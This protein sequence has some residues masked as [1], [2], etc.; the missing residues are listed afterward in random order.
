MP[1]AIRNDWPGLA[2]SL[3]ELDDARLAALL[4][5]R[6]DLASPPPRDWAALAARAGAWHSAREAL[7]GL[8]RGSVHVVE[9]LCLL[10]EPALVADVAGLLDVAP[11]DH[12]LC[13]AIDNLV[14]RALVFRQGDSRLHLLA[15]LR[16]LDHPAGLG[17]PLEAVLA[18]MTGPALEQMARRLGLKPAKVMAGTRA[19]ITA[20][21]SDPATVAAVVAAGPQ[22]CEELAARASAERP[23]VYVPGGMYGF[24][25]RSPA[26][27]MVNRGLLGIVD[28]YNA[29][30][31]RE[32]AV[33]LRGG[34]IFAAGVLRRPPLAPDPVDAGAVDR[35][36]AEQAG[37]LVAAV[38]ALLQM[39]SEEPAALL[40]AGGIGVREVR[41][42]AKAADRPPPE[43]AR[44]IEMAA[45][46]GLVGADPASER[47]VPTA[48]YDDWLAL[49]TPDRWAMLATAWLDAELHVSVAGATGVNGKPIAPMLDRS[50]EHGARRR[51]RL[52]LDVLGDVGPGEA[53][54]PAAV[55]ER[56][57]WALPAAWDYGPAGPDTLVQWT[58]DEAEMLGVAALGSLSTAGRCLIA[59]R[60]QDAASAL[61]ALLPPAVTEFVI[62]ADLTAIIAGEP[63]PALRAELDLLADVESK[64]A[65]TVYRFSE[66]SLRRAFDSGR[67]A[68][69]ILAFLEGHATRGVPQPLAYL[70][71]DLG[72]R[73]GTIR[74]GAVTT[75]VRSDDQG[76]LAEVLR[77]RTLAKL[78]LRAIAPTVLVTHADAADVVAG[79]QAAGYLPAQEAAGGGLV[80]TRPATHR[81]S[82]RRL[83]ERRLAPAPDPWALVTALR[84]TAV[85]PPPRP[86]PLPPAPVRL[87]PSLLDT[88]RPPDIVRG[89]PAVR[90]ALE[91]ACDEFWLVRLSHVAADGR[92][93]ELTVEPT[94][95]AGRYL[96][97]TC[98][99]RGNEQRFAVDRIEWLRVL[100]EAEERL[101]G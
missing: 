50:P 36:A 10:P 73:F 65:A 20:A 6:P 84:T 80:V 55:R 78:R 39:W 63:A 60:P 90:A 98:F 28:Y 101:I 48:A 96:Y 61:G 74:V 15:A 82:A 27:W 46:A 56:A 69:D 2:A 29:A 72:R 52:A 17:P 77:A 64:G 31:P 45:A 12:D 83:P 30:M 91:Q 54:A 66:P 4:T 9:A 94:E 43:A 93:S 40:K 68:G 99:P 16:Q 76:L 51:R 5:L 26:G 49:E 79:L 33:A 57:R 58:L 85:A 8:D 42:A 100:T 21:L 95:I 87:P 14:D 59:G 11:D 18:T 92:G 71:A 47:A 41:R 3:S 23:V 32:P 25:D 24:T 44:I 13:A 38:A 75:Y 97:A 81:L 7:G 34:R 67:G 70:V 86:A 37:G 89:S 88:P 62:Q 19:V 53:V 22:G 1:G 35:A